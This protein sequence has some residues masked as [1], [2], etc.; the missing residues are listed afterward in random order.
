MGQ[1]I[2][3]FGRDFVRHASGAESYIRAQ[4]MSAS[5]L[6]LKPELFALCWTPGTRDVGFAKVVRTRAPG[7]EFR[8][9]YVQIQKKR[10]TPAIVRRLRDEPGPHVIHSFGTWAV[11]AQDATDQL[12][13]EGVE[14]S[15]IATCWELM[16]PHTR[17]KLQNQVVSSDPIKFARQRFL[18]EFVNRSTL[19]A[20]RK[21]MLAA[22]KVVVN[23]RRLTELLHS[24]YGEDVDVVELPYTT[25][26]AFDPVK[27]SYP[28]PEAV[29]NLAFKDGP[30]VI[31]TSRQVPR[32][33][34]DLLIRAIGQL[35]D[36]G[37]PARAVLV[38]RG[39]L[40]EAHRKLV[41]QLNL[42]DR[43]ALPGLV[44]DVR[45]YLGHADI[46]CLPSIAEG[47]GSMSVNEAL[48]FGV[49]VISSAIDGM[50]ED[51]VDDVD[52]LLVEPGSQDELT[53]ALRRLVT[54]ESL[55]AKLGPAGRE[56]FERRFSVAAATDALA[57]LY[58][59]FGLEVTRAATPAA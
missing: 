32:K 42:E 2:Y 55:R 40:L 36:E 20:E 26:A 38:S 48:Q 30:L 22:D 7:S 3:C 56:L 4:A 59:G 58:S 50:V 27:H 37:V 19:P 23:Y 5:Q 25:P 12:R 46:F 53:N 44:P 17:S 39:T 24:E 49:P 33:G 54:D 47:S 13:T 6:G 43:V 15:H 11:A 35:R 16:G 18:L 14:V 8:S 57:D 21:A 9:E 28:V 29:A 10:L 51:L 52:S 31:T 45:E 1:L 34:L 41:K